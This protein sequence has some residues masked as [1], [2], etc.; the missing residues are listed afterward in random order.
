[1]IKMLKG[2]IDIYFITVILVIGLTGLGSVISK[3]IIEYKKLNILENTKECN[4]SII[5]KE[6]EK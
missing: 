3:T 1:M 6:I 2:T 4:C 5:K